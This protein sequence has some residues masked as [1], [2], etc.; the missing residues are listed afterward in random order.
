MERP[1]RNLSVQNVINMGYIMANR[2]TELCYLQMAEEKLEELE[3]ANAYFEAVV[4]AARKWVH[5]EE[6]T[7][8]PVP[9]GYRRAVEDELKEAVLDLTLWEQDL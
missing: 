3:E 5:L 7:G 9:S 1:F 2:H 4:E 8:V 6:A